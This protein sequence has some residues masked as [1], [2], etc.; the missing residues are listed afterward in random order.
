MALYAFA[1]Y[2]QPMNIVLALLA[3]VAFVLVWGAYNRWQVGDRQKAAL[4]VAVAL[5]LVGNILI[6]TVPNDDGRA[7]V[8]GAGR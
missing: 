5:I 2:T 4:M 6:W 7:L 3:A 1:R 8:D